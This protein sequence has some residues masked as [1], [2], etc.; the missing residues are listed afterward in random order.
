MS[1]TVYGNILQIVPANG[2]FAE[3]AEKGEF[4]YDDIVCWALVQ[5]RG[6]EYDHVIAQDEKP[7]IVGMVDVDGSIEIAELASNFNKYTRQ[8]AEPEP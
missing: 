5:W 8:K 6:E 4:C 1:K 7:V 3:Y 2:W